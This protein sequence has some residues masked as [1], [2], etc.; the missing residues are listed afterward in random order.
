VCGADLSS[1]HFAADLSL[2]DVAVQSGAMALYGSEIGGVLRLITTLQRNPQQLGDAVD[3]TKA[4]IKSLVISSGDRKN[5]GEYTG[6]PRWQFHSSVF[7]CEAVITEMLLYNI[8]FRQVVDLTDSVIQT[9][10]NDGAEFDRIIGEWPIDTEYYSCFISYSTRDRSFANQ[11]YNDLV[12]A[13][14]ECWFA[15]ESLRTGDQFRD[16]IIAAIR[17]Y[18]RFLLILSSGSVG[19]DWVAFETQ[20]A[21]S[22]EVSEKRK[23]LLPIRLD[24]AVLQSPQPWALEMR[25]N[26]QIADFSGWKDPET[27]RAAL[28]RLRQELKPPKKMR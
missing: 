19:S 2:S 28:D 5:R 16:L 13:G 25:E 9:V 15:P 22:R 4:R 6:P 10:I 23:V 27:Y 14:V 1:A 24:E 17:R 21:A 20:A 12:S 7:L 26:R 18:D 3:L 11:F 8:S